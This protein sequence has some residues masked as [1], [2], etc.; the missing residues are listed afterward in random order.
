MYKHR[1]QGGTTMMI[2]GVFSGGG[3]KGYA[4][5]GA[6][7]VL[8]EK[9]FSF[10]RTAGT[11][12][13]SI[14][15]SFIIAGYSGKEMEEIMMEMDTTILLDERIGSKLPLAKWLLLYWK[16]GLYKG[17]K[18]EE[19]IAEKL[20][21]KGIFTFK[22]IPHHSFRI[23]ASDVTNGVIMVLPDDLPKYHIDS[24]SFSV[25]KAVRMS[26]SIPYFFEPVKMNQRKPYTYVVDG[27][28]LSNFPMWLFDKDNVIKTRPVIGVKLSENK[29]EL[30]PRKIDNAI[31][32]FG[33]LFETMKDA[34]DNRYI[35]RKHEKNII[36][37]PT[38]N[39]SATEFDL[40]L[41]KK[42]ELIALGR[43]SAKAFLKSWCY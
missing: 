38:K 7:Q 15:A 14:I 32:M 33:A 28:V 2:D 5:V 20:A 40:S 43:Q 4:L 1:N 3:M 18:L 37:I 30:P 41:Q 16:L 31:E 9:G 35:S 22:D 36:F 27:G 11:S 39:V 34:H 8:E 13:G 17:D 21:Q 12:A 24:N 26:C 6:Y 10:E 25:A 29:D 23:I 19:W 42:R